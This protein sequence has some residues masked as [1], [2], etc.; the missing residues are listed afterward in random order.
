MVASERS[1]LQTSY[2]HVFIHTHTQKKPNANTRPILL[3]T[4]LPVLGFTADPVGQ[5]AQPPGVSLAPRPR[6][7]R[8][9]FTRD[10]WGAPRVLSHSNKEES[11]D[12]AGLT[13]GA[14]RSGG[15]S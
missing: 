15:D 1:S 6:G 4:R 10:A 11:V 3:Q 14:C 12:A 2:F 9:R 5:R 13:G 8:V 7:P